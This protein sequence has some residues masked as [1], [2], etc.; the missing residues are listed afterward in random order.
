MIISKPINL[1]EADIVRFWS[2]VNKCGPDDCW[3][4]QA[5]R[6]G[7]GYG[8]FHDCHYSPYRANR[9]AFVITNG[10][11]SLYVLH[12][13]NNPAC[14]NPAHL[15]AGTSNDNNQQCVADGRRADNCGEKHPCVKLTESDVCEIRALYASGWVQREIAEEYGISQGQVSRICRGENWNHV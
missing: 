1:S 13:C 9:V 7:A 10:D 15:Y 6:N 12:G 5:G 2:K 14:C 8:V 4:W 3:E 11:T